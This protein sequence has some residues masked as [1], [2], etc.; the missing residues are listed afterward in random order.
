VVQEY[1]TEKF[2]W[3]WNCGEPRGGTTPIR[4]GNLYYSFFHSSLPNE[5]FRRRYYMGAYCFRAEP[6][7]EIVAM[8]GEPL[9]G[10]SEHDP[11]NEGAPL[12][13]FPN[14]S[15]FDGKNW[16][17]TMGVNDF[18]CGFLKIPH[19]DLVRNMERTE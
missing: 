19:D 1:E 3:L 9:L 10:A 14:G 4:V 5:K 7:F 16:M 18:K 13:V 2:N 8:T 12:C 15:K 17:V 11:R 6:P